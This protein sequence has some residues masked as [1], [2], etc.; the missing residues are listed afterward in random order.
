[1]VTNFVTMEVGWK[2]VRFVV[3]LRT[4]VDSG[5]L[6]ML[7]YLPLGLGSPATV[8]R[9]V[10][11]GRASKRPLGGPGGN[12]YYGRLITHQQGVAMVQP[13]KIG[14]IALVMAAGIGSAA[15]AD[16][17]EDVW[18]EDDRPYITCASLTERLLVSLEGATRK[19]VVS[20]MNGKTGAERPED[21][22]IVL[23]Y[24]S[25]A[26]GFGGY[27]G[28]INFGLTGDRVTRI[29]GFVTGPDFENAEFIWNQDQH[30]QCSDF[31]R[32]RYPACNKKRD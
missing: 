19:R 1:M 14:A 11:V 22:E 21:R 27:G 10:A 28:D 7:A 16:E 20:A 15:R 5:T 2:T 17:C 18:G 3:H 30:F 26:D 25:P 6:Q 8:F 31:P 13:I 23:H 9:T 12:V 32:S 24:A 4:V 29:F